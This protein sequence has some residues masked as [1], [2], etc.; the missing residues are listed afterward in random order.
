ME[1]TTADYK[2]N[3]ITF[4]KLPGNGLLL[5]TKDV[6]KVLGITDRPAGNELSQPEL[7]LASA[8]NLAMSDDPDFAMWLN[9]TFAGYNLETLVRSKWDDDWKSE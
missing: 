7:D 1:V 2:G 3:P 9:E 5:K 6:C 4:V 8:V